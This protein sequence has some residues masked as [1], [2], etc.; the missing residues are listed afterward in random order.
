MSMSFDRW[1]QE[2]GITADEYDATDCDEQQ[3]LLL[4]YGEDCYQEPEI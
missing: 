3:A 4:E 2:E 1:L